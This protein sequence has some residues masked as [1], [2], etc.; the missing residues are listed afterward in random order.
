MKV[1]QALEP[2]PQ[3]LQVLAFLWALVFFVR[4]FKPLWRLLRGP[5]QDGHPT[6]KEAAALALGRFVW[7]ALPYVS[8]AL[9]LTP[10][11]MFHRHPAYLIALVWTVLFIPAL[12]WP[13]GSRKAM[14]IRLTGMIVADV[15]GATLLIGQVTDNNFGLNIPLLALFL[16]VLHAS[17]GLGLL[18]RG[19]PRLATRWAALVL[20]LLLCA[21]FLFSPAQMA[22]RHD[23]SFGAVRQV[24]GTKGPIVD[25][26]FD[27]I[28]RTAFVIF[29][30]KPREIFRVT[31]A[32]GETKLLYNTQ[33]QHLSALATDPNR[34][35]LVA[36]ANRSSDKRIFLF[37][38][39]PFSPRGSYSGGNNTIALDAAV[40]E[41]YVLAAGEGEA[42]NFRLCPVKQGSGADSWSSRTT[43]RELALPLARVG[44]LQLLSNRSL[45]IAAEGGSGF[46]EGWRLFSV[47]LHNGNIMRAEL[48]GRS[49]GG[50]A[51]DPG[52]YPFYLARPRSGNVEVRTAEKLDVL[53]RFTVEPGV[54]LLQLDDKLE[55]LLAT[56]RRTGNFVVVDLKTKRVLVREPVGTGIRSLDYMPAQAKVLIGA[57]RGLIVVNL[58]DLPDL[59]LRRY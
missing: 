24:P 4:A 47:A 34:T 37:D 6:R 51:Y 13:S 36:A 49:V 30:D 3:I 41:N 53:D 39:F 14:I 45:A 23:L 40:D 28:G 52:G 9:L 44:H 16:I 32:D 27:Q 18:A 8:F 12:L 54:D 19:R 59:S 35:L 21:G 31:I 29:A 42:T 43:C 55:L 38:V 48:V 46:S 22:N 20:V 57:D 56:S 25:A 17:T 50:M 15:I 58:A 1:Q 26:V 7:G 11:T 10:E 2:V 33:L 5:R